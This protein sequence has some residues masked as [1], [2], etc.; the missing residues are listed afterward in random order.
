[1]DQSDIL[2]RLKGKEGSVV[3]VEC[4]GTPSS[5]VHS[6]YVG[7]ETVCSGGESSDA[8]VLMYRDWRERR[9]VD[10]VL[11]QNKTLE[12]YDYEEQVRVRYTKPDFSTHF[13]ENH[14]DYE[15]LQKLID[16]CGL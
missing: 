15:E 16:K 14:K 12:V 6:I 8:I 13:T 2:E 9:C 4:Y 10:T 11:L 3:F 1:M 7:T 5:Y